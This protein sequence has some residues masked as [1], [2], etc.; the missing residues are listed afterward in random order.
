MAI[1]INGRRYAPVATQTFEQDVWVMAQV[2][3]AG[4]DRFVMRPDELATDFVERL[5]FEVAA[6]GALLPLLA[7]LLVPDGQAW[8]PSVALESQQ[9]FA[10]AT[11]AKEKAQLRGEVAS[12]LAGFFEKGIA[13]AWISRS[14]SNGA[15]PAAEAVPVNEGRSN[16][17]NGTR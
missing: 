2:R 12:L 15:R 5:L 14:A 7:G 11:D 13:S 9:A 3:R 4:L 1:T 6:S 10:M 8:S 17:A 16:T